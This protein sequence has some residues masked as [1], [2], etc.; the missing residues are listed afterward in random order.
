M[1]ISLSCAYCS[2]ALRLTCQPAS[3]ESFHNSSLEVVI[4]I[5]NRKYLV[6]NSPLTLT[7]S[8]KVTVQGPVFAWQSAILH[9]VTARTHPEGHQ[10]HCLMQASSSSALHYA[11]FRYFQRVLK[12]MIST[13]DITAEPQTNGYESSKVVTARPSG[14]VKPRLHVPVFDRPGESTTGNFITSPVLSGRSNDQERCDQQS[15]MHSD[16]QWIV[17]QLLLCSCCTGVVNVD[18]TGG[19][20]FIQKLKKRKNSV[21]FTHCLVNFEMTQTGFFLNNFRMSVSSPFEGESSAT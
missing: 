4:K 9:D 19:I 20:G 7:I 3:S 21:P 13:T 5:S 1:K 2:S 17:I 11:Q 15:C 10:L 16:L 6:Y 12:R 14:T 8:R 18:V